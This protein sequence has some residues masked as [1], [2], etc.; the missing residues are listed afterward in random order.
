MHLCLSRCAASS[1]ASCRGNC[2]V[3]GAGMI[4]SMFRGLETFFLALLGSPEGPCIEIH[5]SLVRFGMLARGFPVTSDGSIYLG[6][7][8]ASLGLSVN[9]LLLRAGSSCTVFNSSLYVV[10]LV[11]CF[12]LSCS[13]LGCVSDFVSLQ[14][15]MFRGSSSG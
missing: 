5:C 12:D 15:S 10:F 1:A 9:A 13:R 6:P 8:S 2:R 7:E 4:V 3:S 11:F 14:F